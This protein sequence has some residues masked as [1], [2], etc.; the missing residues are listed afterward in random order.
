[1]ARLPSKGFILVALIAA[2]VCGFFHALP[3]VGLPSSAALLA[4][5]RGVAAARGLEGYGT[6]SLGDQVAGW[7]W[8]IGGAD[9]LMAGEWAK[10]FVVWAFGAF[11]VLIIMEIIARMLH[12]RRVR[13]ILLGATLALLLATCVPSIWANV[14]KRPAKISDVGLIAPK[15]LAEMVGK[16]D[17]AEIFANSSALPQL[18]LF[19]PN[20]AGGIAP[21]T[22]AA[23]VT[24]PPAWREALRKSPWKA[25]VLSGPVEEY[26]RLLEHLVTSPDW[27]LE[28]V[29]N[30]G[31]LFLRGEGLP[32]KSL[33]VEKFQQG[34]DADTAV[35]LAQIAGYF[36]AIRRT[37][38]ARSAIDRALELSPQ[39]VT[40]LSHAG[41]YAL[42]HRRWQEAISY[43]NKALAKD[44]NYAH[45]KLVK[46]MALL[47]IN[48]PQRALPL[49]D[50]VLMQAPDDLYTLFVKA[51]ICKALND[52]VA[53][54]DTLEHIIAVSDRA[55]LP[56][57]HYRIYLGQAYAKQGQPKPALEN[58]KAVLASG[59][60]NKE[61]ADEI[62][63]AI[64]TIEAK[65]KP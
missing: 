44:P 16:M 27:H 8:K 60:L 43:S 55:G 25:V 49:V 45:A 9:F 29:T 53:E 31:Y 14:I 64:A 37:A 62:K 20:V 6:A 46:A 56:S 36:D 22:A 41:T 59:T 13:K 54:A 63:D 39:N 7:L 35:Y 19:T 52:Y 30:Q 24:N 4:A 23:L 28:A 40:V 57:M 38:E 26:R 48:Q 32:A 5:A 58:Y 33:D 21:G 61:Q 1:M 50:E 18:L 47:E 42:A 2:V 65:S 17:K 10:L 11:A 15:A 3:V 51:R 12:D 34:S